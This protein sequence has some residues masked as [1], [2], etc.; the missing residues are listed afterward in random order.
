MTLKIQT[1]IFWYKIMEWTDFWKNFPQKFDKTDFFRQVGK[2]YQGKPITAQ[3]LGEIIENIKTK[4]Q[5]VPEDILLDLCCG[6]GLISKIIAADC[7]KMV[8]VD[9][10]VPLIE[11]AKEHHTR[12]N[13]SYRTMSV[14]DITPDIVE[15]ESFTKI[16]MYEALQHFQQEQFSLLLDK[17]M[18]ISQ[19]K[20]IWFFA[21]I[22]DA[23]RIWS[24][25]NTPELKRDYYKQKQEGAL[26]LGTWWNKNF[27]KQVCTE[28]KLFCEIIDQP[29][30][31]YTA[32]YRFDVLIKTL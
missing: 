29:P 6:N 19:T 28:K 12:S 11:I 18:S 14:M 4:L 21:S 9:Y 30:H 2:T 23:D 32:H 7:K 3:I 15:Q 13:L 31:F 5:L 10:S 22:L 27:I 17:L 25:Y 8:A 26:L 16:Y 24:F 1:P 20:A